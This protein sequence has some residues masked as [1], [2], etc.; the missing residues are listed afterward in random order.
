VL[1]TGKTL[2]TEERLDL[3]AS[4]DEKLEVMEAH[5]CQIEG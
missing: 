3:G 4:L 1:R 2:V 5:L